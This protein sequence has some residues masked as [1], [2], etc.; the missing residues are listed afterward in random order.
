MF[1]TSQVGNFGLSAAL[2]LWETS[3]MSEGEDLRGRT[4]YDALMRIKP[5][6][7]A[8]TEWAGRA[9]INRGFFTNLKNQP[10]SPRSDTLRKLL[11]EIG[12][13]EQD[14]YGISGPPAQP[15]QPPARTADGGEVV[16]IIRLDLSLP[17]GSGA[18]I[19]DYVEEEPVTFDLGYIRSFTRTPAHRLRIARG[20]GDSMTPTLLPYDLVWIDGTQ[21]NLNQSDKVWAV[22]INGAAAIK[23]LR[24]LKGGR[25]LVI[26]D[27]PV[28]DNYEVD[29]DEI[30]IGGRVIRFARD[31]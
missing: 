19:D 7:L 9:G 13:T 20:V 27:N 2:P 28:I 10:I 29:A 25:V 23:R 18:T 11:R 15:D 16:E 14:L 21:T 5:A 26:S 17:M 3:D 22:S 31:L 8:E 12:K 30:R 24:P 1:P 4:L 6:G